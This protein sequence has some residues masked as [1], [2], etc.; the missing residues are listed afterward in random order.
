MGHVIRKVS[1]H[2]KNVTII[3]RG[4]EFAPITIEPL[5]DKGPNGKSLLECY[6]I[7]SAGTFIAVQLRINLPFH[8]EGASC[9]LWKKKEL[10]DPWVPVDSTYDWINHSLVSEEMG[11]LSIFGITTD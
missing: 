9:N 6:R 11:D 1:F 5:K 7:E 4:Y 10:G 3:I 8:V 2:A